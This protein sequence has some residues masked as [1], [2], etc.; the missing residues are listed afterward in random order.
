[1][2][3]A[4]SSI[5]ST[6]QC[7][8]S[9]CLLLDPSRVFRWHGWLVESLATIPGCAVHW[10]F[11]PQTRPLP[12]GCGLLCQ[13][14]RL[15]YG[16]RTS[17]IDSFDVYAKIPPA[18]GCCAAG[19]F[20]VIIDL[21]GTGSPLPACGRVITPLFNGMAGEIGIIAAF[22]RTEP[23][24]IEIHDS[25]DPSASRMARPVPADADILGLTL[26]ASL[27]CAAR[28]IGKIV[29]RSNIDALPHWPRSVAKALPTAAT[30]SAGLRLAHILSRK[31]ARLLD[32]M[33]RGGERWAV[34]WR[35][36]DKRR[37]LIQQGSATFAPLLDDGRRYYAD[38]FPFHRGG[39]SFI[40]VEEFSFATER[41][42]IAV[43]EVENG[44]AG[45]PR[46][47]LEEAHHLS[48][49]FV[50]EHEGA[51]WM[52]PEA[53][54]SGRVS[55]YRAVD[56]PYKWAFEAVLI[57]GV[58]GYDATLLRHDNRFWL[59]VCER[60]WHSSSWDILSLFHS[61]LLTDGWA[62]HEHNP[63]L[64]DGM[65][66]RPAGA[67]FSCNG[68]IVRPVQDCS[69]QYGGSIKLCSLDELDQATFRQTVLGG[70]RCEAN[71]CHTYNYAMGNNAMGLEVV[72]V[73]GR[74]RHSDGI[75]AAFAPG[76]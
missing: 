35:V 23:L 28:L 31:L 21:A 59:F 20:D 22:L 9:V 30:P 74:A 24:T 17:A 14:E 40:F 64:C 76:A 7:H 10:C 8:L 12:S 62:P 4:T 33:A 11:A 57:D 67:A 47:V 53:G 16:L 19:E 43:S 56:F 51:V 3:S 41:G 13:L 71:G 65:L 75:A 54:E 37:T 48:Y 5:R 49:P 42:C 55:L 60:V 36:V 72:D 26:D 69:E 61:P 32:Q 45:T 15:V 2:A 27:S 66:S 50:F 46:V 6:E 1:M 18:F 68:R 58:E 39:R 63:V 73:F 38:P 70:I 25:A 29:R 52:I 34:G 44:R